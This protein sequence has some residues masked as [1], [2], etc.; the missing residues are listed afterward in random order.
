MNNI[1]DKLISLIGC[2]RTSC[3]YESA[4]MPVIKKVRLQIPEL[5]VK[6]PLKSRNQ[7]L[8]LQKKTHS[9]TKTV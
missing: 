5:K 2:H 1:P 7:P 4:S 3:H 6:K 9:T 8:H